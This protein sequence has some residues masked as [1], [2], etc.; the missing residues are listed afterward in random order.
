M[1]YCFFDIFHAEH[2]VIHDIDKLQIK[3]VVARGNIW[4]INI[5]III[6]YKNLGWFFFSLNVTNYC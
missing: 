6:I 4:Y 5:L 1:T 3:Y 2:L